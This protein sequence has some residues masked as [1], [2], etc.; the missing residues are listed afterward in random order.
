M[1]EKTLN[2]ALNHAETFHLFV[3]KCK[4]KSGSLI[5]SMLFYSDTSLAAL[6]QI[7][8]LLKWLQWMERLLCRKTDAPA[9]CKRTKDPLH[10]LSINA[11]AGS[12][13]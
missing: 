4:T 2:I 5:N 11:D 8:V 3:R 7:K 10:P 9:G 1:P 6:H 13:S 12:R